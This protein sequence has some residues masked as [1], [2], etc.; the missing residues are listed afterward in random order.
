VAEKSHYYPTP[1]T[2]SPVRGSGNGGA[3]SIGPEDLLSK[4]VSEKSILKMTFLMKTSL[5]RKFVKIFCE[6][7]L[8]FKN[9]VLQPPRTYFHLYKKSF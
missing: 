7:F 1:C 9:I 6:E 4:N 8:T 5:T 3:S 2:H